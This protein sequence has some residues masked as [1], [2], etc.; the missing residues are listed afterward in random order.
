MQNTNRSGMENQERFPNW[1]RKDSEE[2]VALYLMDYF[3]TLDD[4][5]LKEALSIA[6]NDG[7][8]FEKIMRKVRFM[9]S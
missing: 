3:R 8:D 7:V 2:L 5:Y 1:S 6:H 4:Y 9:Q